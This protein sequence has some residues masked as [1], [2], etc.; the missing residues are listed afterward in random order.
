MCVSNLKT[1]IKHFLNYNTTLL[2]LVL[3]QYCYKSCD[4]FPA[5]SSDPL[6]RKHGPELRVC[7]LPPAQFSQS[8][9]WG[10][11]GAL[12]MGKEWSEWPVIL[13]PTKPS[14]LMD[15]DVMAP[16]D[17]E[18]VDGLYTQA[19]TSLMMLWK[20]S[21]SDW[22]SPNHNSMEST[23]RY[24]VKKK[25]SEF[26]MGSQRITWFQTVNRHSQITK[27]GVG[28]GGLFSRTGKMVLLLLWCL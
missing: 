12:R 18:Q 6:K 28:E 17:P 3:L 14:M 23:C 9:C 1:T 4:Y 24:N 11:V 27:K 16:S 7:N 26:T 13:T 2:V 15:V 20:A 8:A 5:H 21:G 10:E 19:H 25:S 22:G